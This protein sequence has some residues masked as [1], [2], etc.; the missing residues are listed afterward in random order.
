MRRYIEWLLKNSEV[1]GIQIDSPYVA[2]LPGSPVVSAQARVRMFG[3]A[4]GMLLFRDVDE[5]CGKSEQ[6][7]E[8]GYGYSVLGQDH[9]N[10]VYDLASTKD[11]LADWGWQG[12]QADAPAWLAKR[13]TQP[14]ILSRLQGWY[15]SQCNGD[16]EHS[17]GISIANIDNPGWSVDIELVDTELY[18]VE[19]SP[20]VVER[21]SS[22]DW[23]HCEVANGIFRGRGGPRNLEEIL[24]IFL[25]WAEKAT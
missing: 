24:C 5:M 7:V 8:A 10:D 16:W 25:G 3:G 11:M 2:S 20:V 21:Q 22:D 1:L 4:N 23:V 19:F 12:P 14:T 17:Y 13:A 15:A 18:G 6:L 9:P